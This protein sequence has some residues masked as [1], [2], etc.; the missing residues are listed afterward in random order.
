[1]MNNILC[2]ISN[3]FESAEKLDR[4]YRRL[5]N[6]S[7]KKIGQD[8]IDHAIN[9]SLAAWHLADKVFN[10]P[11]TQNVLKEKGIKD[12]KAY[13]ARVFNLCPELRICHYLSIK[14]KHYKNNRTTTK[15]VKTVK[16]V[17]RVSVGGIA[18]ISGVPISQIAKI[19][20]VPISQIAKINGIALS[21]E[22]LIV[23][24]TTDGT[25]LDFMDIAA[26]VNAF[27]QKELESLKS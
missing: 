24:T 26:A 15:T 7:R 5:S 27:W 17:A 13:L 18:K 25:A 9:F 1:M 14:Y 4:E 6:S 11:D 23:V 2:G 3:P 10:Y 21:G 20:G 19:S 12:W 22:L 16:S 8:Q